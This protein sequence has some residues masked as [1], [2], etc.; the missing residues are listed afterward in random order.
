MFFH[1][2]K[3]AIASVLCDHSWA[4]ESIPPFVESLIRLKEIGSKRVNLPNLK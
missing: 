2:E 4:N 1:N 3:E